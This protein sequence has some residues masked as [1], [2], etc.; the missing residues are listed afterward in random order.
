MA[1]IELVGFH[2]LDGYQLEVQDPAPP[3][4]R[5]PAQ[6]QAAYRRA[7]SFDPKDWDVPDVRPVVDLVFERDGLRD[8]GVWVYRFNSERTL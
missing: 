1:R 2:R 3:D 8:D 6:D 5:I 4:Y 7:I